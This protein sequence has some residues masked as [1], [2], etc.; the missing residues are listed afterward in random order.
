MITITSWG[1]AQS[2]NQILFMASDSFP[3][4]YDS[5]FSLTAKI[6]I[7]QRPLLVGISIP[8]LVI[9]LI[10]CLFVCLFVTFPL[11][12]LKMWWVPILAIKCTN[13]T[14]PISIMGILT[15]NGID[16]PNIGCHMANFFLWYRLPYKAKYSTFVVNRWL[17][18]SWIVYRSKCIVST[19][20]QNKLGVWASQDSWTSCN[21]HRYYY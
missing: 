20:W 5:R 11:L 6:I 12:I 3:L 14:F 17:P 18:L 19:V 13:I 7:L 8:I 15:N 21:K 9:R 16:I 2:S 10:I 1:V 4:S